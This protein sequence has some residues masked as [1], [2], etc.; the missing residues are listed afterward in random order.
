MQAWN[1]TVSS[2]YYSNQVTVIPEGDRYEFLGWGMPRLGKFSVSHSYFSWLMPR[3]KY[4]LDAN[5]NG[6]ERAFV[7]TGLYD[8]Y[9]PMDIY[10]LYLIKG[11]PCRRYRQDG[12]SRH[13]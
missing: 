9:L 3:K 2:G 6:G 4:V 7:V 5:M 13:L 11:D 8:K 1:P 12:E 10:P